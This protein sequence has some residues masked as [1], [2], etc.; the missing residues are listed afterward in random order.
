VTGGTVPSSFDELVSTEIF[1]PG[2]AAWITLPTSGDLPGPRPGL[3]GVSLDNKIFMTGGYFVTD[4]E[5]IDE[6][7]KLNIET[8]EWELVSHM[9]SPRSFHGISS[10]PMSSVAEYCL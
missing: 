1:V 7:L 2:D 6:I 8:M 3:K 4:E 10:V 9:K 5:P